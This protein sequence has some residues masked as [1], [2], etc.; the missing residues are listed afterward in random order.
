[1]LAEKVA[2][3]VSRFIWLRQFEV[4]N[5]S[6]DISSNRRLAIIAVCVVEWAAA[7]ADATV[8][9]H[10]RV[11]GKT[12]RDAKLCDTRFTGSKTAPKTALHGFS[13]LR[14]AL[15]GTMEDDAPLEDAIVA[16]GG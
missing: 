8:E 9:S 1:M 3:H 2:G 13:N 16:I 10:N 14:S 4:G 11:V 5:N 7:I 12:W 15:L 6:T